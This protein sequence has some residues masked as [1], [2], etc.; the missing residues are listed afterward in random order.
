MLINNND[1]PETNK[2]KVFRSILESLWELYKAYTA[3]TIAEAKK[4]TSMKGFPIILP[5]KGN[6]TGKARQC[7]AH[8]TAI[9][10]PNLST[11][12][13]FILCNIVAKLHK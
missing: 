8:I 3:K 1:I 4:K 2:I 6:K 5:K 10:A 11:N 7:N 9:V 12:P 13:I